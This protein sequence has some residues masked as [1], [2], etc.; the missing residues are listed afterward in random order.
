MSVLAAALL[1]Y[2][3]SPATMNVQ[4]DRIQTRWASLVD[5]KNPLPE[6]PRPQFERDRWM[7]LNGPWKF[8]TDEFPTKLETITVPFPIESTLS[9]IGRPL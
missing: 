9:G 5:H 4:T 8:T 7:S 6:Y 1:A 3:P 2:L